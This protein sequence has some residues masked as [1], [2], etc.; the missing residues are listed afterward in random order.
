LIYKIPPNLPFPKGEIKALF[1]KEREGR[2]SEKG[3]FY[4][5]TTNLEFPVVL[6]HG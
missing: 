4:S 1:G 2:F 3:E 5:E 6:P